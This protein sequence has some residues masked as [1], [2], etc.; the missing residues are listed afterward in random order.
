MPNGRVTLAPKGPTLT[1]VVWQLVP[2]G[3]MIVWIK[4]EPKAANVQLRQHWRVRSRYRDT[5]TALFKAKRIP[6][7]RGLVEVRH[8]WSFVRQLRD[9][10]SFGLALKTVLDALVR[11]QVLEDDDPRHVRL[12]FGGQHAGG[13]GAQRRRGLLLVLKPLTGT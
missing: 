10:D 8:E 5:L 3:A 4:P 1:R 9:E 6:K 12:V 2:D 13:E 7:L 11:A